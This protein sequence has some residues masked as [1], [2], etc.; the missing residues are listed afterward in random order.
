MRYPEAATCVNYCQKHAIYVCRCAAEIAE[1][2]IGFQLIVLKVFLLFAK[3]NNISIGEPIQNVE[4]KKHCR[5]HYERLNF[6]FCKTLL[7]I[8]VVRI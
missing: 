8:T 4:Y 3:R 1:Q 7:H 6:F 5:K 2:R